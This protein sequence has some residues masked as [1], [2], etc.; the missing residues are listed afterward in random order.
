MAELERV[1][2]FNV[3]SR[4]SLVTHEFRI[5]TWIWRGWF[6]L[7]HSKPFKF[8]QVKETINFYEAN[9]LDV[10]YYYRERH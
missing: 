3:F 10:T 5:V 6:T 8:L 1:E 7:K 4:Q 9:V 2:G